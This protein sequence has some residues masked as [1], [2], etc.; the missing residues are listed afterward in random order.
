M[1]FSIYVSEINSPNLN[2]RRPEMMDVYDRLEAVLSD[3]EILLG[4]LCHGVDGLSC[5]GPRTTVAG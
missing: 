3:V 1:K 5:N 2:F 4:V